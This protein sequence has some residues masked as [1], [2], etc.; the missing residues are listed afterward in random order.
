MTSPEVE[1][2]A[3]WRQIVG[4]ERE[5]EHHHE[6]DHLL[7]LVLACHRE[8]HRQYHTTTHVM[9]VLRHVNDLAIKEPIAGGA[10]LAALALAAL[11]HDLVYDPQAADNEQRSAFAATTAARELGWPAQRCTLVHRLVMATADHHPASPEE[12]LLVD[13]DLAVLGAEPNDYSA[14]ARGVRAE[15][16]HVSDNNWRVGRSAVLRGF[17]ALP[18]LYSTATMR[19][20]R[21]ARARAN[22]TAELAALQAL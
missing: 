2:R 12:A 3:A 21:G 7:E 5:P 11:Y 9:W 19:S 18:H 16:Q 13:A 20:E 6:H 8:P 15:Y 1:L 4:G 10:D 14:Y 22:L 17:L